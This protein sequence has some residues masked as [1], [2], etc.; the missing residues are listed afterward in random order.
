MTINNRFDNI[1]NWRSRTSKL[2]EE[3]GRAGLVLNKE[4]Y[5]DNDQTDHEL[6]MN[7]ISDLDNPYSEYQVEE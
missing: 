4:A 5:E 7:I 3:T 1:G 6:V 2:A